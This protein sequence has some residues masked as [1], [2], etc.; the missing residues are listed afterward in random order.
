MKVL[1]LLEELALSYQ[2]AP[3]DIFKGEQASPAFLRVSPGGKVPVLEDDGIIVFDSQAIL[4]HLAMKFGSFDGATPASRAHMLSWLMYVG[5]AMQPFLGQAIHLMHHAPQLLPQAKQRY[6]KD[7]SRH[8]RSLDDHLASSRY[9]AGDEYTVADMAM[10]GW[11]IFADYMFGDAGLDAYPNV[12]RLV[13]EISAR[14]AAV[15]AC[16]VRQRPVLS[17]EFDHCTFH[18]ISPTVY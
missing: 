1:L 4:L 11:A 5:T 7:A 14:P 10:W 16:R 17:R 13:D 9:L 15:A 18:A 3:V 12:K 6:V 8:F 2:L